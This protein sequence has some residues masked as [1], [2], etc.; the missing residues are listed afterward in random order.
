MKGAA[1]AL[2]RRLMTG[3]ALTEGGSRVPIRG[4]LIGGARQTTR[5]SNGV[6]S[7]SGK[8]HHLPAGRGPGFWTTMHMRRSVP[9]RPSCSGGDLR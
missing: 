5:L 3:Q 4:E 7:L 6:S 2:M 1:G 8:L 9:S